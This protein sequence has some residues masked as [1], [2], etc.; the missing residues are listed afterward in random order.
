MK[1]L[2]NEVHLKDTL[3]ALNKKQNTRLS[4]FVAGELRHFNELLQKVL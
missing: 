3:V 4:S 2:R 1:K